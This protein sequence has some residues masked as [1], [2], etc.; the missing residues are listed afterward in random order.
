MKQSTIYLTSDCAVELEHEKVRRTLE[1]T[2]DDLELYIKNCQKAQ[3]IERKQEKKNHCE[4]AG[5]GEKMFGVNSVLE[6]LKVFPIIGSSSS[7]SRIWFAIANNRVLATY[8][9]QEPAVS[10]APVYCCIVVYREMLYKT[11]NHGKCEK[12]V[13]FLIT[14][15]K[16]TTINN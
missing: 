15:E 2:H 5:G 9:G 3:N 16:K 14:E 8:S 10:S 4:F 1:F 7:K 6:V 13:F 12:N 11:M